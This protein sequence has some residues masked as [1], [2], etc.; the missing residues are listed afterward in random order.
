MNFGGSTAFRPYGDI[1][2]KHRSLYNQQLNSSAI[3]QFKN[4]QLN[5]VR[6]FLRL[7]L[8]APENFNSHLRQ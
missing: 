4:L 2:R 8:E 6:G 7:L 1:W 3:G 5:A